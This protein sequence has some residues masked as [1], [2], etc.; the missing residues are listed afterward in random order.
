MISL[1]FSAFALGHPDGLTAMPEEIDAWLNSVVLLQTDGAWCSGAVISSN[2][3]VTAYHCVATGGQSRVELRDGTVLDGKT[4]SAF[5]KSDVALLE[6]ELPSGLEP[7]QIRSDLPLPG[8]PVFALGHP[9]APSA[10]ELPRS[11]S[12]SR[13]LKLGTS[14]A[15]FSEPLLLAAVTKGVSTLRLLSLP[16]QA[17]CDIF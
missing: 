11:A 17:P 15:S 1:L 8:T 12:A 10:E 9:L 16:A 5:P 4:V 7:L 13:W 3:V 14:T 2:Q 6:V